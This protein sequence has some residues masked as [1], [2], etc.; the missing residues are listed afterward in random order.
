MAQT[1]EALN[2][3]IQFPQ[4]TCLNEA[5]GHTARDLLKDVTTQENRSIRSDCDAQLLI[6]I[7]F[8]SSVRLQSLIIEGPIGKAPKR[9]RLFINNVS[10]D[11]DNA[12]SLPSVQDL[13]LNQTDTK[14]G[15]SIQV[16]L[17]FVKFQRVD[18][19]IIFVDSNQSGGDVT[20][21]TKL[22]IVGQ[23]IVVE[24]TKMDPRAV[25]KNSGVSSTDIL[26]Y[27]K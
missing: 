10:M 26:D 18:T 5:E 2:S 9:I 23:T 4:V 1:F 27:Y 12:T 14:Q 15:S 19:L 6:T 24:G 16:Q 7:P 8:N 3:T 11:F 13:E 20:E 21:I 25:T 17:K 22:V